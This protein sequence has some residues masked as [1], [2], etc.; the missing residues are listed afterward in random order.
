MIIQ[1]SKRLNLNNTVQVKRSVVIDNKHTICVS[2]RC[3]LL[4]PPNKTKHYPKYPRTD[5]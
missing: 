3:N 1:A 4:L 2:K 5:K